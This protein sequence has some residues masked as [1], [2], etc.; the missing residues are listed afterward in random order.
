TDTQD[1]TQAEATEQPPV[2]EG[3]QI[4]EHVTYILIGAGTACY[5][6]F[7]TISK[8]DPKARILLIGEEDYVPYMRPPL[9]K[10]LWF[11]EDANVAETLRFVQW[12]GREG[13]VFYQEKDTYLTPK[14]LAEGQTG[15]AVICGK[16]VVGIDS[17]ARKVTLDDGTRIGYDKCLIA[18]GGFPKSLPIFKNSPQEVKD[19]VSFY[20]NVTDFK[21]LDGIV[22]KAESVTI[23]GGGFLG[24]ELACALARRGRSTGLKV[25]QVFPEEGNMGRVFP[26]YL[27]DWTTKKVEEEGVH[28]IPN[29]TISKVE[30]EDNK[31]SL[32]LKSGEKIASDHVILAVGLEPNTELASSAQL[33]VDDKEGGYRVNSELQ[34]RSNIWVAGDA[35]CFYDIKLGRRRVEHHDH[36]V[37][38]GRLAGENMTGAGKPYW[39]QSMFWS[40]LGP[41]IGYEAIGVIDSSLPTVGIWAKATKADSPKAVVEASDD[42]IRSTAQEDAAPETPAVAPEASSNS[43]VLNSEKFGKGIVFYT[44]NDVVVGIIMWNT[45]QRMPIARKV[46]KEGKKYTPNEL[47]ELAKQFNILGQE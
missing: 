26:K 21:N 28:V 10:E 13:G 6:A 1:S 46:L 11:N 3:P 45:F 41:H 9:S 40:D 15:A 29:N 8:R 5:S 22:R 30:L 37:V 7:K 36:A 27:C 19:K 32:S 14:Q 16:K 23:V 20:R 18:T 35:A 12:N 4:P 43:D 24:S 34:A 39:H 47:Q 33:E 17:V 31:V 38:S 2:D 44:R 25:H 42:N